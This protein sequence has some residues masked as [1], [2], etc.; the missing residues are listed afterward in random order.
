[1][2][3]ISWRSFPTEE[4]SEDTNSTVRT[5]HSLDWTFRPPTSWRPLD[6]VGSTGFVRVST[7]DQTRIWVLQKA[8]HTPIT[9][10]AI[11]EG[12]EGASSTLSMK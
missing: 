11:I 4:D 10:V 8:I 9:Q 7:H 6:K 12:T 5:I 2:A 1:M 3:F